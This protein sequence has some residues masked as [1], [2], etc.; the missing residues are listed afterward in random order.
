[1]H[2]L[3]FVRR[4]KK[5]FLWLYNFGYPELQMSIH[6]QVRRILREESTNKLISI[7][8]TQNIVTDFGD[9][10]YAKAAAWA[11][12]YRYADTTGNGSYTYMTTMVLGNPVAPP[13]APAKADTYGDVTGLLDGAINTERL[14]YG[15][16]TSEGDPLQPY[17]YPRLG[18]SELDPDNPGL[19]DNDVALKWTWFGASF[20]LDTPEEKVK[21]G[22][23][24]TAGPVGGTNLF[25]HFLF[26]PG[27]YFWK[28]ID[29][30]LKVFVNH[31]F[32]GV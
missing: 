4:T 11:L 9:D 19:N 22:V 20:D 25:S 15:R 27:D 16:N 18:S 5:N 13:P 14:M 3:N 26:D 12:S 21:N 10:N 24:T 31:T 28:D 7:A 1:M 17:L 8:K 2:P 32:L 30:L 23:I 6:G 29:T